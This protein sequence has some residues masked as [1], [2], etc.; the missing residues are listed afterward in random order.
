M[1]ATKKYVQPV[2]ETL[3]RDSDSP[4]LSGYLKGLVG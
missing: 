4:V 3:V 1:L 2:S